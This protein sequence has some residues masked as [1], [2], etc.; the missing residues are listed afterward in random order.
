MGKGEWEG[1]IENRICLTRA[2]KVER[3]VEREVV[4]RCVVCTLAPHSPGSVTT[5]KLG[6]YFTTNL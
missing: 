4:Q 1:A 2:G 5:A 3:E 6:A